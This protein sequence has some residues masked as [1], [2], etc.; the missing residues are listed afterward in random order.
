[1]TDFSVKVGSDT[2]FQVGVDDVSLRVALDTENDINVTAA[3][4]L[5][6]NGGV[7]EVNLKTTIQPIEINL[8]LEGVGAQGPQGVPG[9]SEDDTMYAKRTD[10]VGD[11]L[12]Y[13]GEALPGTSEASPAWRIRRFTLGADGDVSE[14]WAEGTDEFTHVWTDRLTYTYQ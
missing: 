5:V 12:I 9:V 14:E 4:S 7:Q 11:T 6:I 8:T 2:P 10:F 1:M 3:E 13:K